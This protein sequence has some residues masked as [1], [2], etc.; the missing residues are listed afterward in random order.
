MSVEL[1][2]SLAALAF[3]SFL[4]FW[5]PDSLPFMLAA[6]VSLIMGLYWFDIFTTN[7]GLTVGLMFIA[8]SFV[9]VGYAFRCIFFRD[10]TGGE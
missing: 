2:I 7:L 9:C 1:A 10:R 3:F 4:G 8:Y 6:G 5:R